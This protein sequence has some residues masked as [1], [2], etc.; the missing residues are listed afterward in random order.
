M[1]TIIV[2]E[3]ILSK[4]ASMKHVLDLGLDLHSGPSGNR[5]SQH[6]RG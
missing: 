6:E 4:L 3:G 2:Y 1:F 5:V